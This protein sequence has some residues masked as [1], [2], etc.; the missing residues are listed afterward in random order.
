MSALSVMGGWSPS[1][2]GRKGWRRVGRRRCRSRGLM[3]AHS[4]VGEWRWAAPAGRG[5]P[6]TRGARRGPTGAVEAPT[7]ADPIVSGPIAPGAGVGTDRSLLRCWSAHQSTTTT[8]CDVACRRPRRIA[9]CRSSRTP[10]RGERYPAGTP[11]ATSHHSFVVGT[12]LPSRSAPR[13]PRR[14]FIV[15]VVGTPNGRKRPDGRTLAR[16]ITGH[17]TGAIHTRM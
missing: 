7:S 6:G 13:I 1:L 14:A 9:G 15:N 10:N 11:H 3:G 5:R 12:H 2:V 8:S 16:P 17:R 4:W